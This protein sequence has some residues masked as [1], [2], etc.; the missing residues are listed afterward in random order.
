MQQFS[1]AG[2]R[3]LDQARLLAGNLQGLAL[4][5]QQFVSAVSQIQ[6]AVTDDA[7]R[8]LRGAIERN[9]PIRL[10]SGRA[11][12]RP[13]AVCCDPHLG[14]VTRPARLG[15]TVRL[16]AKLRN[17][18]GKSRTFTIKADQPLRNSRGETAGAAKVEPA[19]L[20]LAPG[21]TRLITATVAVG[22]GFSTG[23]TYATD[24]TVET[25][26]CDP[27]RLP[28]AV[29]VESDVA[30]P[31]VVLCCGCEPPV[32]PLRYYHHF[33]CDKPRRQDQPPPGNTDTI[34]G[35]G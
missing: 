18:T 15:E 35:S 34:G 30:A 28:I 12:D 21:E 11:C 17:G 3:G 1:R 23:F 31:L 32:R 29:A 10:R 33:Y 9:T 8:S 27:Q 24:V 7:L 20:T 6:S 26:G 5:T 22:D 2:S 14:T 13:E 4:A 25:E 19:S 16:T